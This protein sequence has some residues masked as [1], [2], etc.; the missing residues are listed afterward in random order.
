MDKSALYLIDKKTEFKQ[1]ILGNFEPSKETESNLD[2]AG[3]GGF[4]S[5]VLCSFFV[6]FLV[7]CIIILLHIQIQILL[8]LN[9][10]HQLFLGENGQ[11]VLSDDKKKSD[12]A[13][14]EYGF[15]TYV[16]D[17]ISLDRTIP[18]TRPKE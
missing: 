7:F 2:R 3:P 13:N 16:S 4:L 6:F 8:L 14:R 10:Y 9:H 12:K 18:D 1:G 17:K 5:Y 15:D 11:P